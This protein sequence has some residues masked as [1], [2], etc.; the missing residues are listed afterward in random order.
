M[1]IQIATSQAEID[2]AF[3]VRMVVF[4]EEQHVPPEEEL[5]D[6]D[7][8]SIHFIGYENKM[9]IV[10]SRLRF[11]DNYGK[12]ERICVLKE[13]RGKSYGKQMIKEMEAVIEKHGYTRAKLNAQTHAIAFYERL[14]YT[15]ISE[16]FIDAG[17]PH[18]T[19]LK[20]LVNR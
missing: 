6:F 9:P 2:D 20:E 16:E 17:I 15:V 4:V 11:V 18:V 5:D 1:N 10:A 14:G 13:A 8:E 7:Q 19:M 3:Y 12:L